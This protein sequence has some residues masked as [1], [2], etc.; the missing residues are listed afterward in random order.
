M[1]S[2]FLLQF[3]TGNTNIVRAQHNRCVTLDI[4]QNSAYPLLLFLSLGCRE[5]I[6]EPYYCNFMLQAQPSTAQHGIALC[7]SRVNNSMHAM[8]HT[9]KSVKKQVTRAPDAGLWQKRVQGN[10]QWEWHL[11]IVA[12]ICIIVALCQLV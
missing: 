9:H 2:D 10:F 3:T 8:F 12:C 4:V 6:F 7:S 5:N 1:V 11:L